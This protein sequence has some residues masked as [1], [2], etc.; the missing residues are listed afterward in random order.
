MV[1]PAGITWL[2]RKKESA[3]DQWSANSVDEWQFGITETSSATVNAKLYQAANAVTYS[4]DTGQFEASP[5]KYGPYE[6]SSI[7]CITTYDRCGSFGCG[8][9]QA[10]ASGV[11]EGIGNCTGGR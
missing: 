1:K 3:I 9:C 2:R 10:L 6:C 11:P 4:A 7:S 5:H 8:G